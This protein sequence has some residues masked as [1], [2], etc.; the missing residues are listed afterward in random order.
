MNQNRYFAASIPSTSSRYSILLVD[1]VVYAK[2]ADNTNVEVY[3][4]QT[5]LPTSATSG[6]IVSMQRDTFIS[7]ADARNTYTQLVAVADTPNT[8]TWFVTVSYT[9]AN[10]SNT[11]AFSLT[12]HLT[13]MEPLVNSVNGT[14]A[15]GQEFRLFKFSKEDLPANIMKDPLGVFLYFHVTS[16]TAFKMYLRVDHMPSEYVFDVD[17][18][19]RR[20][21]SPYIAELF[22]NG[23][24]KDILLMVRRDG[25]QSVEFG[26]ATSTLLRSDNPVFVSTSAGVLAV[27]VILAA[28]LAAAVIVIA[29][30]SVKYVRPA[31]TKSYYHSDLGDTLLYNKESS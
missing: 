23:V 2:L 13:T 25:R 19:L 7:P 3:L 29:V 18:N 9:G 21:S 16:D 20:Q 12:A 5:P 11:V 6:A 31:C 1:V 14:M 17:S 15:E 30:F 24:D 27:L 8:G 10:N 22:V 4:S 28:L 26:L